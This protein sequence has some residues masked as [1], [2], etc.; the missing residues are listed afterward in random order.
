MSRRKTQEEINAPGI[1]HAIETLELLVKVNK[2]NI[3]VLQA[4][5]FLERVLEGGE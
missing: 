3:T 2:N 4:I 5:R 1:K